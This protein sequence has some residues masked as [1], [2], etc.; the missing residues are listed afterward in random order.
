MF[1]CMEL[2]DGNTY[3]RDDLDL[4]CWTG[5]HLDYI[6]FVAVPS[7]IVWCIGIPLGG[8]LLLWYNKTRYGLDAQH[9]K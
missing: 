8:F 4:E 6:L 5:V 2:D 7:L 1:T 9:V 3:L